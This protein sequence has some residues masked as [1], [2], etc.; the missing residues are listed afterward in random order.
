MEIKNEGFRH[1]K[2][3]GLRVANINNLIYKINH[4]PDLNLAAI[5]EQMTQ[6]IQDNNAFSE[7]YKKTH[8]SYRQSRE[9]G[10]SIF[11]SFWN[12]TLRQSQA[13]SVLEK[14]L[15][16]IDSL[17]SHVFSSTMGIFYD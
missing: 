14:C 9:V 8:C 6:A 12:R 17:Q 16:V 1:W 11:L 15:G 3:I 13:N 4:E 10:K 2:L 7:R 5:R